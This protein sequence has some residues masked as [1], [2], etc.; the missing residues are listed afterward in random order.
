MLLNNIFSYIY[1]ADFSQIAPPDGMAHFCHLGFSYF[2]AAL[3]DN[4]IRLSL[5]KGLLRGFTLIWLFYP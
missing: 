2:M 3:C 5:N 1:S 4:E